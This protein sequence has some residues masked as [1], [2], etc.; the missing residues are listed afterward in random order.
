MK[1]S[2][3]VVFCLMLITPVFAQNAGSPVDQAQPQTTPATALDSQTNRVTLEL[4]DLYI[5]AALEYLFRGS[6][7]NYV[8]AASVPQNATVMSISLRGC[9]FELALKSLCKS[10][11]PPLTYHKE[12][13]LY[14]ITGSPIINGDQGTETASSDTA[15][16][17]G[18]I[19]AMRVSDAI[20]KIGVGWSF[21]NQALADVQ[22]PGVIFDACPKDLA[23]AIT[24]ASAGLKYP[25]DGSKVI[26][27]KGS[28][29]LSEVYQWGSVLPGTVS[30][31]AYKSAGGSWRYTVLSSGAPIIYLLE[32]LFKTARIGYVC[33]KV[34]T[35][36]QPVI[37]AQLY[38]MEFDQVLGNILASVG[39]GY[40]RTGT[41]ATYVVGPT[42][43]R[44]VPAVSKK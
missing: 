22:M 7:Y 8:V 16:M 12:G 31:G 28:V 38:D 33:G 34:T 3:F 36:G 11:D 26:S 13:D 6:G 21:K 39:Y 18:R 29:N 41:P 25:T 27:S 40:R 2:L 9:S 35:T 17:T 15:P 5:R 43:L 42:P 32:S 20:E 14:V 24:L 23:V 44:P 19:P 30:I 10:V 37:S 4:K 1:R